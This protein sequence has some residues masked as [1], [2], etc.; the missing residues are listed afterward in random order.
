MRMVS[1]HPPP[2]FQPF[3]FTSRV[4]VIFLQMTVLSDGHKVVFGD[5]LVP[6]HHVSKFK[7]DV[8]PSSEEDIMTMAIPKIFADLNARASIEVNAAN[9]DEKA[10]LGTY[11][12]ATHDINSSGLKLDN[13]FATGSKTCCPPHANRVPPYPTYY[14]LVMMP[15][16]H[17][18]QQISW[19]ITMQSINYLFSFVTSL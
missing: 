15:S 3:N 17:N 19:L 4:P 12:K 9:G 2:P 16:L 13:I 10:Y 6:T 5:Y 7:I 14:T 11:H 8:T 18:Y 1:L